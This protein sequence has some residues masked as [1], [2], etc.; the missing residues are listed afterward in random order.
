MREPWEPPPLL[1]GDSE[2]RAGAE[3]LLLVP[4]SHGVSAAS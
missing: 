2:D 4:E 1:E 3:R